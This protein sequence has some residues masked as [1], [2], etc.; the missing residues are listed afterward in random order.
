MKS[1]DP[2]AWSPADHPYAIA[3]SEAQWWQ[4]AARLAVLRL[5]DEDDERTG[6]SSRQI[7]ARQL[8]VALRQLLNAEQLEMTALRELGM[9][10]SVGAVLAEAR[11]R[12]KDALPDIEHMRNA[13]MHFEEWTLGKG[14]GPQ[15]QHVKAGAAPATWP[16]STRASATTRATAP[17]RS[18]RTPSTLAPQIE[19][20]PNCLKRSTWRHTR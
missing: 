4:R 12:F 14:R 15:K 18:A 2:N 13:L 16:A 11:Q 5:R 6:F 8:V 19:P 17:S 10:P 1:I 7:D 9:D 20:P 3:V